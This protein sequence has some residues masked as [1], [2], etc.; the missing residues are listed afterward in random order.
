M[1]DSCKTNSSQRLTTVIRPPSNLHGLNKWQITTPQTVRLDP[2]DKLL[3]W[4]TSH[5]CDVFH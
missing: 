2:S 4:I 5:Y 1:Q 3:N